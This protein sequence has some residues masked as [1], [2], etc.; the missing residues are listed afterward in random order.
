MPLAKI[1]RA[2]IRQPPSTR[3]AF[4]DGVNQS[5]APLV[6]RISFSSAMRRSRCSKGSGSRR[7]RQAAVAT[8]WVCIDKV[9]AV[10]PQ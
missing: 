8:T 10:E 5:D 6:T 9:S 7:Q 3:S 4:P 2:L 1:F